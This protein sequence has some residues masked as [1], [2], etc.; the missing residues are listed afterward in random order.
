M[1]VL[2]YSS[3]DAGRVRE[4]ASLL[5]EEGLSVWYDRDLSS[6]EFEIEIEDQIHKAV[7][8]IVIWSKTA[9]TSQWVRAEAG[10]ALDLGKAVSVRIDAT[11]TSELPL[12]YKQ[13]HCIDLSGWPPGGRPDLLRVVEA[14]RA[15]RDAAEEPEPDPDDPLFGVAID[16]AKRRMTFTM[17]RRLAIGEVSQVYLGRHNRR[18]VTVKMI[19][20]GRLA[21][22]TP[23]G[24]EARNT[25]FREIDKSARLEHPCFLRIADAFYEGGNFYVVT[26]FAPSQTIAAVMRSEARTK[27]TGGRFDV[28]RTVGI[29][30]QLAEAMIDGQRCGLRFMAV[31][32]SEIFL[33]HDETS[34]EARAQ[35]TPLNFAYFLARLASDTN[36]LF[37]LEKGPFA[38]PELFVPGLAA[39]ATDREQ[40]ARAID[41]A[42]QFSLGMLGWTLL[43][44]KNP[45][46]GVEGE[47]AYHRMRR[48]EQEA[49]GFSERIKTAPWRSEGQALCRI[50]ERMVRFAPAERW[51]DMSQVA[52][53][54]GALEGEQAGAEVE[55]QVKGAYQ[56]VGHGKEAFYEAFYERL[57]ERAPHLRDTFPMGETAEQQRVRLDG[58]LGQLLNYRQQQRE[59]TTLSGIRASHRPQGLSADDYRDFGHALIETF[60]RRL[61]R[62][63]QHAARIA[64]LEIV[65][66]PAIYYFIDDPEGGS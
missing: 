43:E 3:E 18:P 39:P 41:R 26:D 47:T 62:D 52:H 16:A 19:R 46:T 45:F 40:T 64:A 11:R 35:L 58:A 20:E 51:S 30:H 15:L 23:A 25:A 14:V 17:L 33:N 8:V 57:F 37:T 27:G 21:A 49:P 61:P 34:G 38:A 4:L 28:V 7:A 24:E 1:V 12:R 53:L 2:S 65:I 55:R 9:V 31:N 54:L 50:L 22:S 59:P 13:E 66:W 63:D 29:L 44:G 36:V 48:F 42:N 60:E 5:Q 56:E 6:G 32:P 10:L